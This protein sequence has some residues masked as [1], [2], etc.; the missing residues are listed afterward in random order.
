MACSSGVA[1]CLMVVRDSPN[2]W[3]IC[4]GGA[5]HAFENLFLALDFDLLGGYGIAGLAVGGF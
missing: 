5:V 3:R 2:F 4:G 1:N